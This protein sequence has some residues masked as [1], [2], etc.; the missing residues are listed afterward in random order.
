MQESAEDVERMRRTYD[1]RRKFMIKGLRDLGF[2]IAVEPTGSFYVFMNAKHIMG[3]PLKLAFDILE[4]AHVGATPG[5]DFQTNGAGYLRFSYA[6]S[7]EKISEG[8]CRVD[9]YLKLT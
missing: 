8:L 5:I 7:I 9:S 3:D 2:R 4:K 6:N 1:E